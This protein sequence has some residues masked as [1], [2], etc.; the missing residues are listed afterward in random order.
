[1]I[2]LLSYDRFHFLFWAWVY[3]LQLILFCRRL[4]SLASQ[5]RASRRL[6]SIFT[7]QYFHVQKRLDSICHC[8]PMRYQ[9]RKKSNITLQIYHLALRIDASETAQRLLV[10]YVAPMY[11]A[12]FLKRDRVT[13]FCVLTARPL[14]VVSKTSP[15][16][17]RK[18]AI[19]LLTTVLIADQ[20]INFQCWKRV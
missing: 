17:L 10:K 19:L 20:F 3:C 5:L 6:S 7:L 11:R 2:T 12:L 9:L 1:M 8:F 15:A 14:G 16:L 18:C 4:L 13:Q